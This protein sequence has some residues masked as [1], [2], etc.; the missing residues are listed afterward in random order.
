MNVSGHAGTGE[1]SG[2]VRTYNSERW[3]NVP[4][5]LSTQ[6]CPEPRRPLAYIC[7]DNCVSAVPWRVLPA[8]AR[9]LCRSGR[10]DAAGPGHRDGTPVLSPAA[11]S[12]QEVL[13]FGV[14]QQNADAAVQCLRAELGSAGGVI[15]GEALQIQYV[16]HAVLLL[17]MSLLVG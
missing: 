2:N 10:G 3:R 5:G 6:S 15:D 9:K 4:H 8:A 13:V 11:T 16:L 7:T 1:C 17:V 12:R 14:A